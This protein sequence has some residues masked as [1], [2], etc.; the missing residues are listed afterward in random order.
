M[1]ALEP[2]L[3][4]VAIL[5]AAALFANAVEIFGDRL[6]LGAVGSVLA[7]VGTALPETTIPIVA[8]F[9]AG[10]VGAPVFR[11]I[12]VLG[13]IGLLSAFNWL[14]FVFGAFLIFTGI[15]ML[16]GRDEQADPQDNRVLK[17]LRRKLP[18]TEDYRGDHFVVSEGGK[19]YATPLLAR[20]SSSRPRICFS[21]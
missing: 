1:T 12:F 11:A 4:L 8:T 5:V 16:R 9:G 13:G 10:F 18:V 2:V 6:N 20:S 15:R 21:P 17:F 14:V 3:S 19:R 7:A